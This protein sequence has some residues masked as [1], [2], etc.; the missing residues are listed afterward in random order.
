MFA[1][2]AGHGWAP[3]SLKFAR[4]LQVFCDYESSAYPTIYPA[5]VT[6]KAL[7]GPPSS[8]LMTQA[9]QRDFTNLPI[10]RP[11]AMDANAFDHAT[12]ELSFVVA[13]A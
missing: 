9:I 3:H 10:V 8:G 2:G 13:I 11:M 4:V 6:V 7:T 1:G 5:A 12:W